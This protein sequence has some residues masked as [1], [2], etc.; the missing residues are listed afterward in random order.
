PFHNVPPK[1]LFWLK[2]RDEPS[3]S[4]AAIDRFDASLASRPRLNHSRHGIDQRRIGGDDGASAISDETDQP[5]ANGRDN[6]LWAHLR[7]GGRRKPEQFAHGNQGK[8]LLAKGHHARDRPVN[9]RRRRDGAGQRDDLLNEVEIEGKFLASDVESNE[10]LALLGCLW[11][12][13][14]RD[15][16]GCIGMVPTGAPSER[17]GKNR[18]YGQDLR[19]ATSVAKRKGA[20]QPVTPLDAELRRLSFESPRVDRDERIESIHHD[21]DRGAA[22]QDN[23]PR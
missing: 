17:F 15:A 4:V 8:Q 5:A 9:A 11:R 2:D 10:S 14:R 7:N 13:G 21:R 19:G 22:I 20:A 18:L 3:S 16:S 1:E 6:D 12:V 23:R